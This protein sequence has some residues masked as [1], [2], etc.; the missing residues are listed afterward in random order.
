MWTILGQISSRI[1]LTDNWCTVSLMAFLEWSQQSKDH[2]SKNGLAFFTQWMATNGTKHTLKTHNSLQYIHQLYTAF[3]RICSS[4]HRIQLALLL[5]SRSWGTKGT[6]NESISKATRVPSLLG[7][8]LWQVSLVG[9]GDVVDPRNFLREHF[10][11]NFFF[12]AYCLRNVF[13]HTLLY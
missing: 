4:S 6:R 3:R 1:L 9:A 12:K 2:A 7:F 11:H 8:S 5:E 13:Q 10:L